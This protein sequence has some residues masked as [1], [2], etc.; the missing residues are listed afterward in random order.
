MK[1]TYKTTELTCHCALSR[2]SQERLILDSCYCEALYGLAEVESTTVIYSA[3][4][5]LVEINL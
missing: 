3:A 5:D 4:W 1:L 2:L